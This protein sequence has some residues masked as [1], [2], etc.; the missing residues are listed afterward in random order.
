[1][2]MI[3]LLLMTMIAWPALATITLS[4]SPRLSPSLGEYEFGAKLVDEHS[5]V[6]P[7]LAVVFPDSSG[8]SNISSSDIYDAGVSSA[9]ARQGVPQYK[10]AS[11][12]K[13]PMISLVGLNTSSKA[14]VPFVL[15]S[16]ALSKIASVACNAGA[17]G[18]A[19]EV[20]TCTGLLSTD[21]VLAVSQ[22]TVGANGLALVGW[23]T[24]ANNAIT[25]VWHADPGAGSV[26]LVAVLHQ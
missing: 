20:L 23:S 11:G 7:S 12:L 10:L 2:R 13:I 6:F 14:V 3:A 25:G 8:H 1:M 15:P 24:L 22:K 19:T 4:S 21:T 26:V 18:A 16:S 5:H 9:T 17:G